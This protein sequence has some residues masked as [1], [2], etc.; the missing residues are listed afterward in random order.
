MLLQLSQQPQQPLPLPQQQ[1]QQPQQQ[2]MAYTPITKIKKFTSKKDNVQDTTDS[3]YQSLAI[4]PQTFQAFKMAFLG[5]FSNNNSINCLA[6]TFTTIKQKETEAVTT[7]LGRFHR[8][9]CQIQTIQADYFTVPQILNQFI[10]GLHS[11]LLQRIHPMHPQTLQD[12]V[13]NMKDFELA[14]LET[15]HAQA[16][17]TDTAKLEIVNGGLLTDF[18]FHGTTI[19]ILTTEFGHWNYLSLLVIPEDVPSNNSETTQ[20][21]S[22][23][24]NIPLATITNDKSLAAIFPFELKK[25]TLVP[26]FSEA[27]L[28]TKPITIMYTN[29]KVNGHVIKLILD[30]RSAGSIITR[31][32]MDQLA[33][34]T[35]IGEI[36]NFP[37]EVNGIIILIKVLVMEATQYQT[38]VKNNWLSKTNTLLD[39]NTQELQISQNEQH[40]H[41]PA[42]CGHFRTTNSTTPLIKFE[43]K[44]KKPIWEVYQVLWAEADH[45]K[46]PPILFWDDNGKEKQKEGLIWNTDQDWETNNDSNELPT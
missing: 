26:L 13:T 1:L 31:Q 44:E 45:N 22:L 11:S 40:T 42:M 33:T 20:K 2:L 10:C 36:D 39:W 28:N 18:Q 37:F 32:L 12:A 21:Q 43:K 27:T 38:L 29:V 16:A 19:R 34:K 4:K 23:T 8:N 41:V 24:N 15:N 17:K 46:L 3:W 7:Y 25:T 6:N 14:E 9:L 30:S 35:P 5:Y